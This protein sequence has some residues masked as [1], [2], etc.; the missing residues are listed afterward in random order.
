MSVLQRLK[1]KGLLMMDKK[2]NLNA[3]RENGMAIGFLALIL[4]AMAIALGAFQNT[5]TS[6]TAEH[7]I[8]QFGL[9]GIQ[10]AT[11]YFGTIGTLVGVGALVAVVVVAFVF[12]RNR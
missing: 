5:L 8:T 10:N 7:N 3:V 6:G 4:A 1:Q 2:G 11:S 9:A 12:L